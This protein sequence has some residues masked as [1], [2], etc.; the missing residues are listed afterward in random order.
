[1]PRT[2]DSNALPVSDP[3]PLKQNGR[4]LAYARLP[5]LRSRTL[6]GHTV[7]LRP[8]PPRQ[9]NARSTDTN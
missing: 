6:T 2:D 7:R 4:L 5:D 1:M 3:L 9:P 8:Q